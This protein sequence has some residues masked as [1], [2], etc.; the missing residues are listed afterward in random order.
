MGGTSASEPPMPT[1]TS[2]HQLRDLL[3]RP[4]ARAQAFLDVRDAADYN[5]GHIART[6]LLPRPQL[7]ARLRL[8]V[9]DPA[10]PLTLVDD[11]GRRA[12]LAASTAEAM[13]Y[14]RVAVLQGGISAW[15]AAGYG[16]EWGSNVLSKDFGERVQVQQRV[17]EVGPEELHDWLARGENVLLLD[18]RTPEEHARECIPG[19]RNVP[20]GELPLRIGELLADNP[21][22]TVVVHCAGRTRSIIGARALLRMGLPR[23]FALRNGTAGWALAGF[24]VE[25][26]SQRNLLPE[27]SPENRQ[28]AEAFAAAVA[29]QDGVRLVNPAWLADRLGRGGNLYL[30]DVRTQQEYEAGHVPGFQ[31][32]PGG[33]AVQ[34]AEDY[35]GVP[36]GD[37]VFC[38]DGRARAAV[39]GGW[40]RQ[41]GYP[42]VYV[43]DGG[44]TAWAAAG[45]PLEAGPTPEAVFGLEE[46]RRRA[47]PLTPAEL[48]AA[49]AGSEPPLVLHVGASRDYRRERVAGSVWTPRGRLEL[50]AATLAP[51]AGQPVVCTC[52]DGVQAALAAAALAALGYRQATYLDGGTGAWAA[53]GLPL[54]GEERFASPPR[55]TVASGTERDPAAMRHYL[56]WE[57][58][59]GR[60]YAPPP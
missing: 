18:S 12:V 32:V 56:E 40:Y 44:V 57:E 42:N 37:I 11:D 7:E 29:A 35:V 19:A 59:L 21:T 60:K 31:W 4:D 58:A 1:L 23:V 34:R 51:S 26:G 24:Q 53:A 52:A 9:P 10:T 33:Q 39:T 50:D 2:P 27:P 38:C 6:T 36:A 22:A 25:R 47:R 3:A 48:A 46:A 13:G 45:R 8:V 17:P 43:L 14:R 55:D 20:G 28:R 16:T 30:I 54:G 5:D 49:L 15:L 41:M